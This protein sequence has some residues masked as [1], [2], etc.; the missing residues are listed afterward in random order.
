LFP[1]LSNQPRVVL[2]GPPHRSPAAP[3]PRA[4][5]T[6]RCHPVGLDDG[7][8]PL[9]PLDGAYVVAVL[10]MSSGYCALLTGRRH[11]PR[12][13]G[14]PLQPGTHRREV[15]QAGSHPPD[16]GAGTHRGRRLRPWDHPRRKIRGRPNGAPSPRGPCNPARRVVG[17]SLFRIRR[18]HPRRTRLW[19]RQRGEGCRRRARCWS[20][21]PCPRFPL[22]GAERR[23]TGSCRRG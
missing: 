8:G 14:D 20:G 2:R 10:P 5:T 16:R 7:G 9:R 13:G 11:V 4:S 3:S 15:L 17:S 12:Q 21:S 1:L 22:P 19:R 23:G 18:S 6:A